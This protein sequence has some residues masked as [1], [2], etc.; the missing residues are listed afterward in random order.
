MKYFLI[1]KDKNFT[2]APDIINWYKDITFRNEKNLH[3]LKNRTVFNKTRKK[4]NLDRHNKY[5]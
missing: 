4:H 3:K 1:S 5:T 2:T